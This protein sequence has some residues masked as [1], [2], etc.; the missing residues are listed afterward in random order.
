MR[1][2]ERRYPVMGFLFEPQSVINL[3]VCRV[4]YCG[5]LA[6]YYGFDD[7]RQYA[8]LPAALWM[9]DKTVFDWFS[10]ARPTPQA[11]SV[12]HGIW[13]L[14][15]ITSCLGLWTR[16]ST[17]VATVLAFILISMAESFGKLFHS[18]SLPILILL[19]LACSRCGDGLSL[20]AWRRGERPAP[21]GDYRWPIRLI[22]ITMALILVMAGVAK[23][24]NSGLEWMSAENLRLK[25]I[26]HHYFFGGMAPTR[27]GLYLAQYPLACQFLAIS[28]VIL[29]LSCVLWLFHRWFRIIIGWSA[30]AMLLGFRLLMGPLFMPLLFAFMFLISWDHWLPAWWFALDATANAKRPE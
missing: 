4:L 21:S 19:I 16:L 23:L 22:W 11:V 2:D 7:F 6:V 5:F 10:L 1:S 3:S 17:T 15:L 18:Q 30:F 12:L 20:D 8:E 28:T 9:P 25:L 13:I 26:Q 14:S 24:R 29:E 27:W